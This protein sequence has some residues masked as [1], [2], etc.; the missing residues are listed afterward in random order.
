MRQSVT[1][2]G[3]SSISPVAKFLVVIFDRESASRSL[4]FEN[5]CCCSG[6]FTRSR[7]VNREFYTVRYVSTVNR[8]FYTVSHVRTV[9]REYSHGQVC[10]HGQP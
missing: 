10:K 5:C 9:N 8:E 6:D 4:K 7:T 2:K 3:E 1:G